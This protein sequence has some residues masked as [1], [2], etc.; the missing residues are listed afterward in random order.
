MDDTW[1]MA[2]AITDLME[3]EGYESDAEVDGGSIG[4]FMVEGSIYALGPCTHE[5]APLS[6]G[7]LRGHTV[8]CPWHSARFDLKTGVCIDGPSACRVDGSVSTE[9]GGTTDKVAPCAVLDVKQIDGQIFV[10][11][12]KVDPK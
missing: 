6:Q 7:A 1:M 4:L 9:D 11:R 2:A 10:R 5:G 12:R 3:G 8:V